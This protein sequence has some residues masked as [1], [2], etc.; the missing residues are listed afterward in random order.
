MLPSEPAQE[1]RE[2]PTEKG[3]KGPSRHFPKEDLV[4]ARE[5]ARPEGN[6]DQN[7]KD[8]VVPNPDGSLKDKSRLSQVL[9]SRWSSCLP[10]LLM[11]MSVVPLP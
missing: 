3:A 11:G 2:D 5:L 10:L 4:L 9:A 6:A 1:Y 7:R 8:T